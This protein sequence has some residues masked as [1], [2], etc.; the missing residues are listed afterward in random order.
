MKNNKIQLPKFLKNRY[1]VW[2]TTSYLQ[3][4]K[5]ILETNKNIITT[6]RNSKGQPATFK[7]SIKSREFLP[8]D[9]HN[10]R[11]SPSRG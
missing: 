2:K 3:N 10:E 7:S 8:L 11:Q 5:L 4:E 9:R 6:S 1:N